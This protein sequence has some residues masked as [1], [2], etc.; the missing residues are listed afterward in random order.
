MSVQENAQNLISAGNEFA[1]NATAAT[2]NTSDTLDRARQMLAQVRELATESMARAHSLLGSGHAG[3]G[4]IGATANAVAGH[5]DA[6]E[7]AIQQA[8]VTVMDLNQAISSH[9]N[10]MS[11]VGHALLQGG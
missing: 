7:G 5:A 9:S 1:Q 8:V 10:T 3:T 4:S 2:A 6:V 11:Q